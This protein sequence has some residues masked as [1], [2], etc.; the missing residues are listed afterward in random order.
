M[1]WL[2]EGRRPMVAEGFIRAMKD[3]VA[4]C[5]AAGE[6]VGRFR[7][8]CS[9]S[10]FSGFRN[11]R[12]N[13]FVFKNRAAAPAFTGAG[14]IG[15]VRRRVLDRSRWGVVTCYRSATVAGLHGLPRTG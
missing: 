8:K 6:V 1:D 3:I 13:S 14:P 2:G 11:G 7:R 9:D 12:R 5:G 4:G 10:R 15:D